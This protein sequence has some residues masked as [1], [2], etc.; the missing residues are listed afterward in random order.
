MDKDFKAVF[1]RASLYTELRQAVSLC[2][3]SDK[4]ALTPLW[5]RIGDSIASLCNDIAHEAPAQAGRIMTAAEHVRDSFSDSALTGGI[6]RNELIPAVLEHLK[7]FESIE[8]DD[9][10]W[11]ISGT[12]TGYVTVR[13][14]KSGEY[15]HSSYDP[16]EEAEVLADKLYS[17]GMTEFHLFGCG[18]GYLPYL[19]WKRSYGSMVVHVY[20]TDEHM[21]GYAGL[22]GPLDLIPDDKVVIHQEPDISRLISDYR[23]IAVGTYHVNAYASVWMQNLM[24]ACDPDISTWLMQRRSEVINLDICTVNIEYNRKHV[25]RYYTELDTSGYNPE[26]VVV[27]AGPSLD[28]NL[29][30]LRDSMGKRTIIAVSTCIRK[31]EALGIRPDLYVVCDPFETI[32]PHVR[33]HG[34]ATEGIPL[35]IDIQTYWE[36]TDLYRGPQ[37]LIA[38]SDDNPVTHSEIEEHDLPLWYAGGT[39]T[40]VAIEAACVL[41]AEEVYVIGMDLAYPGGLKYSSGLS[42]TDDPVGQRYPTAR[43]NDGSEVATAPNF[44]VYAEQISKQVAARRKEGIHF[45]NLARRGLYIEGMDAYSDGDVK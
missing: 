38:V 5:N 3:I 22:F 35:L 8:V 23:K 28:E 37:Y 4:H 39:V 21:I 42:E 20:D 27:A 13:D 45:H 6:I 24:E 36:F 31:L 16:Y 18:L 19:L 2:S 17:S 40:S 14:I 25:G 9:G 41:G 12:P 43:A 15:L 10:N 34:D 33:D 11:C 7:R 44:L 32:M 26:W 1:D 29:E 30:F